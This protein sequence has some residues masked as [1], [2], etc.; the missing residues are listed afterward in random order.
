MS[1]FSMRYIHNK[2]PESDAAAALFP[3]PFF[4]GHSRATVI[5]FSRRAKSKRST[6]C[7][8]F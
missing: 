1:I 8:F 4:S 3:R 2:K 6:E 5:T 7:V